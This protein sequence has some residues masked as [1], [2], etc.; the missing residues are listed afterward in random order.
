MRHKSSSFTRGGSLQVSIVESSSDREDAGSHTAIP[1]P[2]SDGHQ[3][4]SGVGNSSQVVAAL[5]VGSDWVRE[6]WLYQWLTKEPEPEVIVI[7]LRET[8]TVGPFIH[9]LDRM[10]EEALPYWEH[11]RLK[12]AI[13]TLETWGESVAETRVGQLLGRLLAPPDPPERDSEE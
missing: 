8:Y 10:I 3:S 1:S 12:A 4:G 7:D 11:S 9:L 2:Q 13:D 6:S 5:Q